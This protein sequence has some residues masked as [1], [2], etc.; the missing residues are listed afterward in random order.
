[1]NFFVTG[2]D[3]GVGKSVLSL[4]LV[5][6]LFAAGYS[7]R[8]F[9]PFQTGRKDDLY[10]DAGFIYKNVPQLE[11][12]D[13]REAVLYNFHEPL[14]PLFAAEREGKN[15][16]TGAFDKALSELTAVNEPLVI[17]GSGGLLVPVTADTTVVDFISR[18]PAVR[19]LVAARCGLGTINHTLL[20]LEALERRALAI[21]GVIMLNSGER[22][23]G[24]QE[25]K[26]NIRAIETFSAYKVLGVI[27]RISNFKE[28][29][30]PHFHIFEKLLKAR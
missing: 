29:L 11:N 5:Q 2:T 8:Y 25:V 3:T 12:R 30:K 16:E 4:G 6:F 14:A 27:P 9:K 13:P 10:G 21:A 24:R 23:T 19:V 26:E 17:E 15:V 22:E 20:T 7:P 1:M 28:D 18:V